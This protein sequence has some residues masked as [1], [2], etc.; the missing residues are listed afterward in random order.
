MR[1]GFRRLRRAHQG[2]RRRCGAV[3]GSGLAPRSCR[4]LGEQGQE[5]GSLRRLGLA[6]VG[7]PGTRAGL[8]CDE[9]ERRRKTY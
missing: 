5:M 6:A 4:K 1:A 8:V 9:I 2:S 7:R 3:Q